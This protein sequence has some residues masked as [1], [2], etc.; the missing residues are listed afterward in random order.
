MK[1]F[2][3][4]AS[5]ALAMLAGSTA[6]FAKRA[7]DGVADSVSFKRAPDGFKRAPDGF[8]RAPDGFKRA[9]DGI[10]FKRAPD[11]FKR[12]PDGVMSSAA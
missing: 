10:A 9:P 8:K 3:I 2:L 4:S 12:A 11:G 5:V 1:T 7:P 6:V